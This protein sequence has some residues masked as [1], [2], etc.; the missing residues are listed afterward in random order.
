MHPLLKIYLFVLVVATL[1]AVVPGPRPREEVPTAIPL[2]RSVASIR[3]I[4]QRPHVLGYE[5]AE[6]GAT[7]GRRG[8]CS[9]REAT[10][11]AAFPLSDGCSAHGTTPD[12]YTGRT[13]VPADVE[14]DH[15][16]PLAAAWDLGAAT[17]TAERRLEFANDPIN[18]VAV[19]KSANREKSD[20]LPSAWLPPRV[21]ARCWYVSALAHVAATYQLRLSEA[22]VD[23]MNGQ[24]RRSIG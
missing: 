16:F 24:C 1:V 22:D 13:L 7:W 8:A 18:L 23:A 14:I 21:D 17:W 3:V 5:R 10:M 4:P 6:F 9:T 12:P 15:I 20:Q 2:E 11:V 19:S